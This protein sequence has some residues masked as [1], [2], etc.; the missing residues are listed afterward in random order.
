MF[1]SGVKIFGTTTI[2]AVDGSPWLTGLNTN[3]TN[4]T[5]LLRGG[6]WYYNPVYCRSALRFINLPDFRNVN[7][8][9][10]VVVVPA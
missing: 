10:R 2:K 4:T 9:F 1:G 3:N 6:S 7:F 5:R 8:G